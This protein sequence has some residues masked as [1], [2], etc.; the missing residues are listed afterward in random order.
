MPSSRWG[1]RPRLGVTSVRWCAAQCWGKFD[2]LISH[3][4]Q[5]EQRR[6]VV[7]DIGGDRL[8]EFDTPDG[9]STTQQP[10]PFPAYFPVIATG[11]VSTTSRIRHTHRL[12]PA[13]WHEVRCRTQTESLRQLATADG[14][15]HERIRRVLQ[16]ANASEG[17]APSRF[18]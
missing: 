4:P 16:T 13:L 5:E 14:V 12:E 1:W 2:I 3:I 7:C 8:R 15:P 18:E 11:H 6:L 9:V 17:S 10:L